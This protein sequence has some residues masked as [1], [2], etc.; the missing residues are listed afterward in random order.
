M[1]CDCGRWTC[2][3]A[4]QAPSCRDRDSN[5]PLGFLLEH[6]IVSIVATG[7]GSS[8]NRPSSRLFFHNAPSGA[9]IQQEHRSH[10]SRLPARKKATGSIGVA[11]ISQRLTAMRGSGKFVILGFRKKPIARDVI[12]LSRIGQ[13]KTTDD[14][15]IRETFPIPS[16]AW[17][18]CAAYRSC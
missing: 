11:T 18:R 5:S 13:A 17:R 15:P 4:I 14:L 1:H 12:G 6:Q 10:P 2:L 16:S 3:E 9:R 7:I 8:E